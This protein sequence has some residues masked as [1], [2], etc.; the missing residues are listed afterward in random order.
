MVP[1]AG[2][3][4]GEELMGDMHWEEGV[5]SAHRDRIYF[6]RTGIQNDDN[7]AELQA[8]VAA[9]DGHHQTP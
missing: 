9:G 3:G 1:D 7:S 8:W 4:D 6:V 5:D 2:H